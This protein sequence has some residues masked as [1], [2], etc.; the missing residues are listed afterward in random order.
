MFGFLIPLWDKIFSVKEDLPV[1]NAIGR[2]WWRK[3]NPIWAI[4]GNDDDYGLTGDP[5]WNPPMFRKVGV[6][7]EHS[8][9]VEFRLVA[10]CLLLVLSIVLETVFDKAGH[11]VLQAYAIGYQIAGI[12]LLEL[13]PVKES[14]YWPWWRMIWWWIRNPFHNLFF[15]VFGISDYARVFYSTGRWHEV[16]GWTFHITLTPTLK[17]PLPF[18]S[19]YG[20]VDFYLGW[21]PYGAF[22]TALRIRK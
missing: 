19:Y 2:S 18:I 1:R 16:P 8:K 6:I 5:W 14:I 15:Y 20:K 10:A 3:L 7:N 22:G 12:S 13:T 17:F 9:H 21:R 11:Y 4:F